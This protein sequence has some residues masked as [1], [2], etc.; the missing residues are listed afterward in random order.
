MNNRTIL[1]VPIRILVKFNKYNQKILI[2]STRISEFFF[3]RN[4][5]KKKREKLDDYSRIKRATLI[6]E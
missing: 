2:C 5:R 4:K 1:I 6:K 3:L